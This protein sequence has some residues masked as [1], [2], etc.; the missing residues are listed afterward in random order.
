MF[1]WRFP[2]VIDQTLK[3]SVPEPTRLKIC[4]PLRPHQVHPGDLNFAILGVPRDNQRLHHSLNVGSDD[5]TTSATP[6][7]K[8]LIGWRSRKNNRA[9]RVARTLVQFFDVVTQWTTWNFQFHGFND[10][11]NTKQQLL[12]SLYLLKGFRCR[13][14][15]CCLSILH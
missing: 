13:F 7:N 10:N 5:T 11:V 1:I 3:I 9:A 14:C 6:E 2:S 12:H 15:R 4:K 8:D